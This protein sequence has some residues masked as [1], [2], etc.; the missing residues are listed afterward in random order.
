[1]IDVEKLTEQE[2]LLLL[3]AL[4]VSRQSK[5]RTSDLVTVQMKLI[6]FHSEVTAEELGIPI[7][8]SLIRQLRGD[9]GTAAV[10]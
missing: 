4:E 6:D 7:L 10:Q 2:R 8:Q 3:E 9:P 1:M 5:V